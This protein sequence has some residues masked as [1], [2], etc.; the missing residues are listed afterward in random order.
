M[1]SGN[2]G[3]SLWSNIFSGSGV[4]NY[5][6]SSEEPGLIA[7]SKPFK[8]GILKYRHDEPDKNS[9]TNKFYGDGYTEGTSGAGSVMGLANCSRSDL[10]RAEIEEVEISNDDDVEEEQGYL[11]DVAE[12]RHHER[13]S[14]DEDSDESVQYLGETEVGCS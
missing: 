13:Q 14:N 5:V 6:N 11:Y 4:K 1:Y 3:P 8:K 12:L 9:Q 2:S 10:G 7:A